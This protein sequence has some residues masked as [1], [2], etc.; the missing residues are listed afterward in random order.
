MASTIVEARGVTKDFGTIQAVKGVDLSI[1]PGELFGLIGHNGAGKSTLFKMMLGLIPVTSGTIHL[2]GEPIT[3]PRFR[4]TRRKIGYLPENVV[5]Y[6]NLTG[7]ETLY[8]FA[9][10]KAV[11]RRE[12]AGLLDK[13]GLAE[14]ASRRVREYSKG[15]R[16]RLGFAQ[17][18]LGQPRLLFLDEPTTG[19]DPGA[20]RDFY[21]ILR[22]LRDE[23]VTMVLTSH[24][25]AEI[26]ERVDRLAIMEG[27]QIRATGTV[28]ALREAMN[29]PLTLEIAG[30]AGLREQVARALEGLAIE[31]I[32][33]AGS[34]LHIRLARDA[35][36]PA[37]TRL[38]TLGDTLRDLHVREPSL[39]DVFFGY[40]N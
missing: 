6:D 28:Q 5:L 33:D 40:R 12:C 7:L 4:E 26:Q 9:D 18:L 37:L 8:F 13:V 27:G 39:E 34:V 16:Q 14:A 3:G 22:E 32:F 25:L 29:L 19:L 17:A 20:I 30:G 15:M 23:G 35:K 31:G 11:P 1:A 10:L 21:R 38:A 2:D 24:I 36:M